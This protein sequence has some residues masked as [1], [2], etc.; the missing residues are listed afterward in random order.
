MIPISF[1]ELIKIFRNG[2][3]PLFPNSN[4]RDGTTVLS[5]NTTLFNTTYGSAFKV[6]KPS[7]QVLNSQT[8]RLYSLEFF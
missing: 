1:D 4:A 5:S 8:K 2:N 6:I 3:N 7:F